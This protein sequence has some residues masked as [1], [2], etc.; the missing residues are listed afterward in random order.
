M[1]DTVFSFFLYLAALGLSCSMWD[2]GSNLGSLHWEHIVL[3]TGPPGNVPLLAATQMSGSGR[4]GGNTLIT[5]T[6]K[7]GC[8][9][10]SPFHLFIYFFFLLSLDVTG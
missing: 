2:Q 9:N 7:A 8:G 3:A 1:P 4:V 10:T 5:P 6:L